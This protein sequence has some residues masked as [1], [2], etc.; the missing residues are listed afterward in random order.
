MDASTETERKATMSH[1]QLEAAS[2]A[3]SPDDPGEPVGSAFS[4]AIYNPFL[5][6][7]ER[8]GM[9]SRRRRLL[10]GASGRVLEIGAG[11]GLN[12]RHYP[13]AVEEVVLAEPV[14]EMSARIDVSVRADDLAVSVVQARAEELPFADDAFDTVVSTMVLCTVADPERAMAEIRRVLRPGGR[15]LFCEHVRS[16]SPRLARWQERL[17]EPWAAFAEGCRCDRDTLPTIASHLDVTEVEREKWSG[18]V[19]IIHPLVVGEAVA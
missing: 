8:R 2:A 18:M 16:D 13:P 5:W 6:L 19:P 1:A 9:R 3:V 15:L 4:A 14:E 11:T 7:G 17:A 12:L 10:A